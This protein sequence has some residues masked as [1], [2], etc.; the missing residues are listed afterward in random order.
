MKYP[1]LAL[2]FLLVLGAV[3]AIA[4][5]YRVEELRDN[6]FTNGNVTPKTPPSKSEAKPKD[7]IVFAEKTGLIKVSKPYIN[8]TISS[9]HTV[10]GQAVGQWYFE[11]SFPV[12]LYDAN[13]KEI[14]VAV[15]QAQGE[16]MTPE[17]VPFKTTLQFSTPTTATGI[18]VFEKDNPSGLPEHADELR[19]P[20]R[21]AVF[22]PGAAQPPVSGSDGCVV[23][24]CSSQ[25]CAEEETITTC[26]YL[27]EY[28]CYRNAECKR[29][30]EGACG[31]TYTSELTQCIENSRT[32]YFD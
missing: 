10:E 18:L 12:R 16:W 3:G 9:P 31:W 30:S 20:I 1:K 23:T 4:L 17:F 2:A 22:D 27:P 26:E 14:A 28:A 5:F 19:V 6:G 32:Q 21:F 25:I 15:A 29:Q 24:G 7:S 8:A 11:A 13:G